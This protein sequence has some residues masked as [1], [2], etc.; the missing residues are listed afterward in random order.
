MRLNHTRH[1]ITCLLLSKWDKSTCLLRG[2]T[3]N[4]SHG[5][6]CS[7]YLLLGHWYGVVLGIAMTA[8]HLSWRRSAPPLRES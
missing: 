3:D 2:P 5:N 4:H 8:R 1:P 6:V 7:K